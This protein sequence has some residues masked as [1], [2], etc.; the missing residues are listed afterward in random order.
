MTNSTD[1]EIKMSTETSTNDWEHSFGKEIDFLR[2]ASTEGNAP[3]LAMY[4]EKSPQ[5]ITTEAAFSY[6]KSTATNLPTLHNVSDAYTQMK[7]KIDSAIREIETD[8]SAIHKSMQRFNEAKSDATKGEWEIFLTEE[9]DKLRESSNKRWND[10]KNFGREKIEELPNDSRENAAKTY[11]EGLR[12][13]VNLTNKV[14]DWLEYCT[15]RKP[16][17]PSK[18]GEKIAEFSRNFTEWV[19]VALNTVNRVFEGRDAN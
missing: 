7:E 17:L 3:F 14:V 8:C 9:V 5:M 1:T 6:N 2:L 10:L 19:I 18:A 4:Q 15:D 12:V 11:I 13:C 16:E